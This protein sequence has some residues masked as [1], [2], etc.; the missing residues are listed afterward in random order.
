PDSWFLSLNGYNALV[1]VHGLTMIFF[2]ILVLQGAFFNYFLPLFLG[3]EEM[4]WPRMN[5]LGAWG[6]S[7]GLALLYLPFLTNLLGIT[8]LPDNAG[9]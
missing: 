3:C 1:T 2:V 7:A 6:I 5:A 9:W 4:A 8:G